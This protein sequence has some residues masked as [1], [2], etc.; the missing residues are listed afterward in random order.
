M[1][2]TGKDYY[3]G[4]DMGTNS[5]GWAVTDEN[6]VLMRAKG[7]DLWGI[8]EFDEALTAVDRRTHRVARRRRQRE[9]ARIGLLKEY[10]HD[11]IAEVDPD[12]YQRLDNSKYH[13]ED[14][15]HEDVINQP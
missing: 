1:R 7:K 2:E 5:V 11:A 14:K 13:E 4:L 12:F 3:L 9:I 8:R 10:F 6:Y 15:D